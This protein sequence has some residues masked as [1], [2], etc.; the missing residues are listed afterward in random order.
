M[1]VYLVT[2]GAYDNYE[3]KAVFTDEKQ[4]QIYCAKNEYDDVEVW[5]TDPET[6]D[7]NIAPKK[8]WVGRFW[9]ANGYEHNEIDSIYTFRDIDTVESSFGIS[10]ILVKVTLDLDVDRETARQIVF[11]KYLRWKNEQ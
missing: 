1:K 5:D 4:A 10:D 3:I 6:F 2:N 9:S 11:D 7:A 8:L